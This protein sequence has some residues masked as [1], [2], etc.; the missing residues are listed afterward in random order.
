[1]TTCFFSSLRR[2]SLYWML[3]R[4]GVP[5]VLDCWRHGMSLR[6][7]FRR[8]FSSVHLGDIMLLKSD[9]CPRVLLSVEWL[10][11]LSLLLP[12]ILSSSG[13]QDGIKEFSNNPFS[14]FISSPRHILTFPTSDEFTDFIFSEP[15]FR[16]GH[17][18]IATVLCGIGMFGYGHFVQIGASAYVCAL[19]QGI[20]MAGVL[21]GTISSVSYALD[22]YR[23]SSN[24]LFIMNMLFKNFMFYGISYVANDWVVSDGP[25]NVLA[26]CGGT[27]VALVRSPPLFLS[28]PI[29]FPRPKILF[30]FPGG[31]FHWV[32]YYFVDCSFVRPSWICILYLG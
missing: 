9:I 22:A 24:E 6:Q 18:S 8:E 20:M 5:F 12:R 16:L 21:V 14:L 19:F 26:V 29:I 10:G 31:S 15:E 28:F 17:M 27:S 32:V 11:Q 30:R 13:L 7:L 4:P 25:F 3:E 2:S 23:E 1:M